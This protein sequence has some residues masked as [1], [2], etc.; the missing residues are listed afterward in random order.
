MAFSLVGCGWTKDHAPP[1]VRLNLGIT[2]F[3]AHRTAKT[4]HDCLECC[5]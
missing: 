2:E 4:I 5:L 1:S 3:M